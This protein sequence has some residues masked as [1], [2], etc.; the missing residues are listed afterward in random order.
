MKLAI[1]LVIIGT[2]FLTSISMTSAQPLAATGNLFV[3]NVTITS[4]GGG[5]LTGTNF[6]YNVV[7]G[8]PVVGNTT[9]INFSYAF[10][11]FHVTARSFNFTG[12]CIENWIITGFQENTTHIIRILND[13]AN[14]GTFLDQPDELEK[15]LAFWEA[16]VAMFYLGALALYVFYGFTIKDRSTNGLDGRGEDGILPIKV[17]NGAMLALKYLYLLTAPALVLLGIH[18]AREIA[19]DAG[20]AVTIT[21]SLNTAFQVFAGIYVFTLLVFLLIAGVSMFN[22]FGKT[23]E[24]G[25][26]Q[27]LS[28]FRGKGKDKNG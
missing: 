7:I 6:S 22:M 18:I 17:L 26:S 27:K 19:I 5:N 25:F 13:S 3:Y 10:G 4:S 9:G 21:D 14:C 2:I 11:F 24:H 28:L 15:R 16:A 20:A 12:L 1:M 23:A 8:E